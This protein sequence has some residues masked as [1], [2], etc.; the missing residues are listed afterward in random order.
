MLLLLIVWGNPLVQAQSNTTATGGEAIGTGGNVSFTVGQLAY[1]NYESSSGSVSEGVQQA[2]E[3]FVVTSTRDLI[4]KFSAKVFPNPT[5]NEINLSVSKR[6][7]NEMSY[8][9]FNV[10]GKLLSKAEIA[11]Q[12]T[13]IPFQYLA[14]GTYFIQVV[15][16]EQPVQ[17]F[18]IIKH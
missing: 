2:F 17:T 4:P 15:I 14:G 1:F 8:S 11:D 13:K 6:I 10:N 18:K 3:I 16:R 12:Q 5:T 7:A 9:L